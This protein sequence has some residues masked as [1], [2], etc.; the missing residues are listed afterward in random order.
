MVHAHTLSQSIQKSGHLG[1]Q[2]ERMDVENV[3]M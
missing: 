3:E 2:S 1:A